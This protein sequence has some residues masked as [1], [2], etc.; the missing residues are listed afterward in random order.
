HGPYRDNMDGLYHWHLEILPKLS[1]AAGFELGSGLMIN[2]ALPES[3][4]EFLRRVS[5]E[6][7]ERDRQEALA[8]P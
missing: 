5:V 7:A 8:H 2:T 6:E 1:I 3:A 4:A